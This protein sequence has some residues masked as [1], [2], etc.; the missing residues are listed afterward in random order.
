MILY[1]DR[2]PDCFLYAELRRDMALAPEALNRLMRF[3]LFVSLSIGAVF[4]AIGA[5]PIVGFL[6]LDVLLVW[7]AFKLYARSQARQFERIILDA[8]S[9]YIE[10]HHGKLV[11]VI[12]YEPS[13]LAMYHDANNQT[14]PLYLCRQG[15]CTAVGRWLGHEERQAAMRLIKEALMRRRAALVNRRCF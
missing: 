5:W 14:D 15:R 3:L 12:H 9:L 7:G 11:Q 6:G 8:N 4:F 10:R 2:E 13:F 1:S